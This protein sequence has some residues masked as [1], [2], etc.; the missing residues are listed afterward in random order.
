MTE[1]VDT[2]LAASRVATSAASQFD[3]P[4]ATTNSIF[5]QEEQNDMI[6]RHQQVTGIIK[7][8][9]LGSHG[10]SAWT[11]DRLAV[12]D[13]GLFSFAKHYNSWLF[14]TFQTDSLILMLFRTRH[15]Y[16]H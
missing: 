15:T 11:F 12:W 6:T 3:R 7:K 1:S 13:E 8:A 9:T 5:E 16:Y 10:Q 2:I 4:S 14:H